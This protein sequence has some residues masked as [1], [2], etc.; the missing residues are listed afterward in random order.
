M[1]T[2]TAPQQSREEPIRFTIVDSAL[3]K[4]LLAGTQHGIAAVSIGEDAA[5]LEVGLRE[6]FGDARVQRDDASLLEWA[7]AV[8]EMAAG[9]A[10]S[11]VLPL[12][13]RGTA[14]QKTVWSALREIPLGETRSYAELAGELGRPGAARA[15][16]SA[17]ARNRVAILVP[18]HR[19]VRSGGALGGY[20]WGLE[21]KRRLLEAERADS[22]G[23]LQT[24][25]PSF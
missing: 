7:G 17:C 14:F 12:D 13:L 5:E 4:L 18:C 16:A 15:V 6:D 1:S 9:R 20:R 10:S 25:L 19:V 2:A 24:L 8:A 21:R 22:P 23:A 3:G 11:Q